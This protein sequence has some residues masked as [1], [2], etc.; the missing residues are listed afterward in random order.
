MSTPSFIESPFT[1]KTLYEAAVAL[2][3]A[4]R[5]AAFNEAAKG[6]CP[7]SKS[8]NAAKAIVVTIPTNSPGKIMLFAALNPK[9]NDYIDF[10]SPADYGGFGSEEYLKIS[11]QGLFPAAVTPDGMHLFESDVILEYLADKYS[12]KLEVSGLGETPEV[13]ARSKQLVAIHN[14]Y[15]SGVNCTQPDFFS[16]QAIIYKP[17]MPTDERAARLKDLNKQFDLIDGLIVGPFAT[18]SA[19]TFADISLYPTIA[20]IEDVASKSIVGSVIAGRPQLKAWLAHC[21]E[22]PAFRGVADTIKGFIAGM[23]LNTIEKIKTAA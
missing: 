3:P 17:G 19:I 13:R 1:S 20:M 2:P 16:N 9:L 7:V 18:G 21:N 4:A 15:I 6:G 10:K 22:Q 5:E 12:D 11:P 8:S 23:F 14:M